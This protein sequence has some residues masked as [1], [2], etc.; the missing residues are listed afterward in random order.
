MRIIILIGSLLALIGLASTAQASDWD[1]DGD[2]GTRMHHESHADHERHERHE[3]RDRSR[4]HHAERRH[5]SRERH[6][7]S[8][9]RSERR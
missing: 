4:R 1:R 8:H 9:E 6:D 5:D 2:R 7:E 3:Y